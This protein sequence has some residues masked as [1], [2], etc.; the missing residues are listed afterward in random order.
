MRAL[1]KIVIRSL[2][3]LVVFTVGLLLVGWL[4]FVPSAQEPGYEFVMAWG[5]KGAFAGRFNDPTGVRVSAPSFFVNEDL[6]GWDSATLSISQCLRSPRDPC[7][8]TRSGFL[9]VGTIVPEPSTLALLAFGLAAIVIA[10]RW[11]V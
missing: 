6:D 11:I 2:G 8:V 10:R 1:R 5:G 9:A 4:V 3:G 7:G